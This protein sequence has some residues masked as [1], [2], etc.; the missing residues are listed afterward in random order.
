MPNFSNSHQRL[1]TQ[2]Q[3]ISLTF[4]SSS[5]NI[6]LKNSACI[7]SIIFTSKNEYRQNYLHCAGYLVKA[8]KVLAMMMMMMMFPMRN[9]TQ[10][11]NS[12]S[13]KYIYRE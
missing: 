8:Q 13:A 7:I 5:I 9:N 1:S 6:D 2:S 3:V 10:F 4:I 11:I 12:Y